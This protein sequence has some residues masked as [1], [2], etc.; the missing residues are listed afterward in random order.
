MPVG[1]AELTA[2]ISIGDSEAD[3]VTGLIEAAGVSGIAVDAGPGVAGLSG[4]RASVLNAV[5][6]V[7]EAA[8]DSGARAIHIDL[9]IPDVAES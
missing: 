1:P 2:E 7:V 5:T 8:V 6:K 3:S 4:D 9:H